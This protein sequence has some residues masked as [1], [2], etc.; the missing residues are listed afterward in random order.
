MKSLQ[1]INKILLVFYLALQVGI[2]VFLSNVLILPRLANAWETSQSA[3]AICVLNTSNNVNYVNLQVSF[4][5]NEP[6]RAMNVRVVDNW[7]GQDVSLGVVRPGETK[8]DRI[9]TGEQGNSRN[10]VKSVTF[11]LTWAEGAQPRPGERNPHQ[12]T[13]DYNTIDCPQPAAPTATTVP[14]T[15]TPVPGATATPTPVAQTQQVLLVRTEVV[16]PTP[17][18][19]VQVLAAR[20]VTELPK[21]GAADG[22]LFG[23]LSLIP[24]GIIIRQKSKS[25]FKES[26]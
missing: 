3:Q 17:T 10:S 20:A 2:G 15:A 23:L 26:N 1:K 8:T 24:A 19:Q 9:R 18:P 22:I 5:N 13:V 12:F 25:I 7:T 6:D 11:F 14:P 4:T 16:Q 21:T